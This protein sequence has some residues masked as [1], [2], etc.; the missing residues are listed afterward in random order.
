MNQQILDLLVSKGLLSDKARTIAEDLTSRGKTLQQAL[1]GGKYVSEV[2]FAKSQAEALGIGYKDLSDVVLDPEVVNLVPKQTLQTFNIAPLSFKDNVLEVVLKDPQD[3]RAVESLEFLAGERG[4]KILVQTAPPSQINKVLKSMSGLQAEVDVALEQA[5]GKFERKEEVE[6][7]G[8]IEDVIKGAPVSRMLSVIMRH[9][10]E[11]GASDIHIEPVGNES[12][13]RYRVDGVLRTSLSLP[14]YVHPALV[15]RVKVLANLKLDETRIPQDGRIRQEINGKNIDFRISTLPVVDHEK[16]VMRILD[17]TAGAPTLEQLGF[18]KQYIDII[19]E[20]IKKPHGLFL[21]TGPTGSGKSTTLFSGLT[22]LNSDGVNI[23]TL[24]DPVEYYVA[25]VNQSQIRP[26][27]GYSFAT[28]LRSLL[29]QDPNVIM[30]G[31]IRDKES[32]ELAIHASLTGHLIFS[33][34]HTNDVHG[35]VPRLIDI[36]VEPFLL[37]ATMNLGIAQRLARKICQFCKEEEKIPES[38]VKQIEAELV[39]VPKEYLTEVHLKTPHVF[40]HGKGCTK[41]GDTGYAGRTAVAELFQFTPQAQALVEKG[42]PKDEF[43]KEFERQGKLTIRQDLI[44]KALEGVTSME[45][46]LRLG[47]EAVETDDEPMDKDKE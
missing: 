32:A 46:V 1:V 40:Y 27:I 34:L 25:G 37:A 21:I 4:W 26:E 42:F 23:S 30:V 44:L 5:K 28:G 6:E 16:V 2:D 13:I 41:C 10:V 11:G 29:R 24:E 43:K 20:E 9:A 7:K 33:T 45:E 17:T 36:G 3:Y 19:L 47:Q 8:S 12:R 18:R 15:S 38:T 35:L 22:I 14:I 39:D 31:E